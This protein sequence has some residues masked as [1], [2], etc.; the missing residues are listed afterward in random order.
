MRNEEV[1]QPSF[2]VALTTFLFIVSILV[3]GIFVLKV[4]MHVL[5]VLGLIVTAVMAKVVGYQ[6]KEIEASMGQGVF[7][8]MIGMFIFILIGMIIEQVVINLVVNA[9]HAL[10]KHETKN[11]RIT[12]FTR[13]TDESVSIEV[14]DNGSG[15][16]PEHID[17]VFDPF[18]TT[19][20]AGEGMGLGLSITENLVQGLGGSIQVSNV[21]GGGALFSVI[22]PYKISQ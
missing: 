14:Q 18:F 16:P 13:F 6:W 19:K 1:R 12:V 8:A 15:I 22:L 21:T 4:D 2:R 10:E 20:E 17:R 3:I 9:M 11:K 5:L 7:R